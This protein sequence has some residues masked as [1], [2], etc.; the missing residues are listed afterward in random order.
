MAKATT[1]RFT[2]EMFA[3]LDQASAQ[4]G[5]PINSIVVAACLEWMSRHVD[6]P[7]PPSGLQPLA[8]ASAA[9][10]WATLRRAVE[11][12]TAKRG[13]GPVYPFERFTTTAQKMLTDAQAEAQKMSHSY[14]GT[15]HLLLAAFAEPG[16]QSAKVLSNIGVSEA[17]VRA[18]I[19]KVLLRDKKLAPR[20]R[21]VPTSRVKKVIELA[22]KLCGAAAEPRVTTGHMLLA[23]STEGQGIAA[24]VLDDLGAT[25]ERIESAL[26]LLPEPET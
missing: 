20:D 21:I 25:K 12:A 22:F 7:Q 4:T 23:L 3:R 10:R 6:R 17:A 19:E 11:L 14:I 24:H 2:D 1:V 5:M 9:P 8:V 26:D 16:S 15:E 18:T 13:P